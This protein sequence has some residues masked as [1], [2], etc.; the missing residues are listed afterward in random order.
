MITGG[1][2]SRLAIM[3]W[4]LSWG[5]NTKSQD[6]REGIPGSLVVEV[7]SFTVSGIAENGG[8]SAENW[9]PWRWSAVHG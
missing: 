2:G 8:W 4:F 9:I 3:G 6:T 5:K 7:G 1:S